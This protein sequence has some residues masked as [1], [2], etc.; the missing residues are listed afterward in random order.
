[1]NKLLVVLVVVVIAIPAFLFVLSARP[2][3]V[4]ESPPKVIGVE[5][6][7][8]LRIESR[9][10]VRHILAVIEQNGARYTV[11]ERTQPASRFLFWRRRQAPAEA[12]FPVGRKVAPALKDGKAKLLIEA[13]ANDLRAATD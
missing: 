12:V 5:T 2:A 8:R 9:H 6:P 11:F 1:M 4:V 7:I 10:G 3:L 13:Q